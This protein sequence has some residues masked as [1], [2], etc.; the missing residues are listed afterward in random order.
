MKTSTFCILISFVVF[1]CVSAE[2][3]EKRNFSHTITE[4]ISSV[5]LNYPHTLFSL[6]G[7]MSWYN[8]IPSYELG[9]KN[10]FFGKIQYLYSTE[11]TFI[12]TYNHSFD[13]IFSYNFLNAKSASKLKLGIGPSLCEHTKENVSHEFIEGQQVS[14]YGKE[15]KIYV[16]GTI[17]LGYVYSIKNI[18]NIGF[19]S[20][21]SLIRPGTLIS[22]IWVNSIIIGVSL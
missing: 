11:H 7:E 15:K 20:S 5:S 6:G 12:T 8:L 4:R 14:S 10:K 3:Q 9:Y 17:E 18:V 1:L 13:L 16:G 2:A 21:F 22:N 19:K